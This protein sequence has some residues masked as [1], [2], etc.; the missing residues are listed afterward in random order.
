MCDRSAGVAIG[1]DEGFARDAVVTL[2]VDRKGSVGFL[3]VEW[4]R[5]ALRRAGAP[6]DRP[7]VSLE[8]SVS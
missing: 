4:F 6:G 3:D 1:V 2:P 5:V 8:E 7:P